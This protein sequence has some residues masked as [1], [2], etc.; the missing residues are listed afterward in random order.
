MTSQDLHGEKDECK[1][2][3][4]K[5]DIL[6]RPIFTYAP[7][8]DGQRYVAII[9]GF[10]AYFYGNTAVQA[11]KLADDFRLSHALDVRGET[12]FPPELLEKAR[13]AQERRKKRK[14]ER[15]Q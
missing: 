13:A 4:H 6:D 14:A 10:P 5:R 11:R 2:P 15:A 1:V 3:A 12:N 8:Q 9:R 7:M